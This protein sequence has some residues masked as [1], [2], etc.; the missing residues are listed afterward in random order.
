MKT[1]ISLPDALYVSANELAKRLGKSRS[2]LYA[3]AI[4]DYIIRHHTQKITDQLNEVYSQNQT[5]VD[6]E[7]KQLQTRSFIRNNQW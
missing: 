1:A 7:L 5:T 4:T 6:S 3:N 2:E